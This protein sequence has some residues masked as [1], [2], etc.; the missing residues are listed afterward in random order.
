MNAPST[1]TAPNRWLL[2]IGLLIVFFV[3]RSFSNDEERGPSQNSYFEDTD[4]SPEVPT[5]QASVGSS[6]ID[7]AAV[8]RAAGH[9]GRVIGALG[10]SGA[11]QYSELCYEALRREFS[12]ERRDRCYAFDLFAGR[13]L[14]Q[15]SDVAPYRFTQ[16]SIRSRWLETPDKST[17]STSSTDTLRGSLEGIAA[18]IKVTSIPPPSA[19]TSIET[20]SDVD[21]EIPDVTAPSV[22]LDESSLDAFDEGVSDDS[23][24]FND[25]L[26]G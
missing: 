7:V 25:I 13:L 2:A 22:P 4:R 8:Q 15:S 16:I 1:K 18:S 20:G 3:V 9:A 23:A 6:T 21:D 11:E 24:E 19:S 26:S 17:F 5:A 10:S 12:S 14:E